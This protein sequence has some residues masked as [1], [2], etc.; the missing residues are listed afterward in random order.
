MLEHS[1]AVNLM[2]VSRT[3]ANHFCSGDDAF[4]AAPERHFNDPVL[5]RSPVCAGFYDLAY[6]LGPRADDGSLPGLLH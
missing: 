5:D 4:R 2:A 1:R 6:S 3:K